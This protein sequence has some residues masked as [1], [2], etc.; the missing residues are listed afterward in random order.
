[1]LISCPNI[2]P[3]PVKKIPSV[4]RPR[5]SS[6]RNG[7]RRRCHPRAGFPSLCPSP[8]ALRRAGR[9]RAK[10]W[11]PLHAVA[12]CWRPPRAL[13]ETLGTCSSPPAVAANLTGFIP[14]VPPP[15]TS[16]IL[17]PFFST[18]GFLF[19]SLS[20]HM[21]TYRPAPLRRRRGV[22]GG[23]PPEGRRGPGT[24]GPMRTAVAGGNPRSPTGAVAPTQ[25]VRT[26][27]RRCAN[28]VPRS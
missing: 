13:D 28:G 2:S 7:D 26:R 6:R 23:L 8:P 14:P 27:A 12:G 4:S 24:A 20:R 15:E 18:L 17:F 5:L 21:T 1:V 19:L 11:P 16:R 9:A 10:P 3:I 25:V 22:Q